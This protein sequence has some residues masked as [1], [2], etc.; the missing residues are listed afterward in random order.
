MPALILSLGA[1]SVL[2]LFAPVVWADQP[3][4]IKSYVLGST[5]SA[6][7]DFEDTKWIE[8]C[9]TRRL[10][11]ALVCQNVTDGENKGLN[12]YI[13]VAGEDC[14]VGHL[15][16]TS[17]EGGM[18]EDWPLYEFSIWCEWGSSWERVKSALTSKYGETTGDMED[19]VRGSQRISLIEY[20]SRL[21]LPTGE[22]MTGTLISVVDERLK[23]AVENLENELRD[24]D[25]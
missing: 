24:A 13:S 14:Y 12:W 6:F 18:Y 7:Y 19:W 4:G 11:A 1:V 2:S 3:I 10:P 8:D 22:R 16:F 17:T 25:I 15:S 21:R 9:D 23:T 5:M 20:P